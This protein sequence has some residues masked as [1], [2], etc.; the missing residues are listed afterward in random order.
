MICKYIALR[1]LYITIK[2]YQYQLTADNILYV[3]D[4]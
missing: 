2:I 4:I 3:Q 1:N